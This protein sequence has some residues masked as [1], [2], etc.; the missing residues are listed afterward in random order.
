MVSGGQGPEIR[1]RFQNALVVGAVADV[2]FRLAPGDSQFLAMG[3]R[4]EARW[5]DAKKEAEEQ[6]TQ[7]LYKAQQA[8]DNMGYTGRYI[9]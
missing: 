5:R 9:G 4:Y 6:N 1:Q 8:R 2:C 7:D 3:D